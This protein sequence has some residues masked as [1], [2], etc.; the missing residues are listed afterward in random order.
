MS[1]FTKLSLT[2]KF[3]CLKVKVTEA[4]S[5]DLRIS[6]HISASMDGNRH[7]LYRLEVPLSKFPKSTCFDLYGLCAAGQTVNIGISFPLWFQHFFSINCPISWFTYIKVSKIK[8]LLKAYK[9]ILKMICSLT[10]EG[11]AA[12]FKGLDG[13]HGYFY[14]KLNSY[15]RI[16]KLFVKIKNK[17][18]KVFIYYIL[19]YIL[20]LLLVRKCISATLDNSEINN[21]TIEKC[22]PN[23]LNLQLYFHVSWDTSWS[24]HIGKQ[25]KYIIRNQVLP[26]IP[27]KK[28]K[29][30]QKTSQFQ[31]MQQHSNRNVL[32]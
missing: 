4:N 20:L 24:P 23:N 8:T 31:L 30:S 13:I 1:L 10:P 14:S 21:S 9:S 12:I 28:A 6:P 16:S 18:K 22:A 15:P 5:P 2:I 25:M 29:S 3:P 27:E 11:L 26:E 19:Q 7:S 17:I 32:H